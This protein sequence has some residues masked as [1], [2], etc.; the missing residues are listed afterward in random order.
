MNIALLEMIKELSV[1]DKKDLNGKALKL[2]EETGELAKKVLGYTSAPT[3]QHRFT[4][5]EKVLE[6][7]ADSVLCSLSVG[8]ELDFTHDEI[9]EEI[10]RKANIWANLQKR[11][12][13][14]GNKVPFEIH[15]TIEEANTEFFIETCKLLNVK[16]IILDLQAGD[17]IIKDVMTS[18]SIMGD[19]Q[20][21]YQ[22]MKRISN[23]LTSAGFNVIRE[24]IETVPWHTAAPSKEFNNHTMPKDSYFECHF[25]IIMTEQ[26]D[27]NE[28]SSL[29]DSFNCHLSKNTFKSYEDGSYKIMVTLRKYEGYS[30]DFI[31]QAEQIRD[32]FISTGFPVDKLITEFSIFDSKISHDAEWLN[33]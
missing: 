32:T 13:R 7:V 12:L 24:K 2:S 25:G 27:R 9:I 20:T 22:E 30:E 21:A 6:E 19:N 23:G 15:V 17:K 11:E 16:P 4:S 29:C 31:Y 3:T 18:S 8:Y 28:L 5:R 10:K 1:T 26:S 33:K 14:M